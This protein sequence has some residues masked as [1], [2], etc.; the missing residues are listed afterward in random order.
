MSKKCTHDHRLHFGLCSSFL[1]F[2]FFWAIACHLIDLIS[3]F[4]WIYLEMK[5]IF[6]MQMIVLNITER[7]LFS[8]L[9][10]SVS[11]SLQ[12]AEVTKDKTKRNENINNWKL[13]YGLWIRRLI[14][15]CMYVSIFK[16]KKTKWIKKK[17]T[18]EKINKNRL[19]FRPLIDPERWQSNSIA[20]MSIL[21]FWLRH[22][23]SILLSRYVV[24]VIP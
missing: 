1:L 18:S 20:T 15:E 14:D 10:S 11:L 12:L 6:S 7:I 23:A 21:S 24:A 17:K 5:N 2:P 9:F 4:D 8:R 19:L 22:R 13:W 16:I 3:S